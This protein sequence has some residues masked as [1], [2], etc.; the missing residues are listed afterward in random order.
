MTVTTAVEPM[1]TR[2]LQELYTS[3]K[4]LALST[5]AALMLGGEMGPIADR[6]EELLDACRTVCARRDVHRREAAACAVATA[7]LRP[8]LA[9][10]TTPETLE[11]ARDSHL[12]LRRA[13]WNVIPCEYV[14]CC[15]PT[16][17]HHER[18]S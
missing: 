4:A 6:I 12:R 18:R 8:L 14:P 9:G 11:R 1:G 16:H 2:E 10:D 7:S 3:Y 5:S 17:D 13:I 15:A